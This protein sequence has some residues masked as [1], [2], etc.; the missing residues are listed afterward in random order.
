MRTE[1]RQRP[2]ANLDGM[3]LLLLAVRGAGSRA[4]RG[5]IDRELDTRA[6]RAECH[7]CR[8]A[9][10]ARPRLRLV[11]TPACPSAA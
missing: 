1:S 6:L 8:P 9:I 4:I 2:L 7:R 5:M 10:A 3:E 11:G